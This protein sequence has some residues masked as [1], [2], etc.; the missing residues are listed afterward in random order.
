F[1]DQRDLDERQIKVVIMF[2]I[3]ALPEALVPVTELIEDTGPTVE[4]IRDGISRWGSKCSVTWDIEP[5]DLVGYSLFQIQ[6]ALVHAM[7]TCRVKVDL[8]SEPVPRAAVI[9]ALDRLVK[10]YPIQSYH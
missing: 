9:M 4:E 5:E 2:G 8:S 3:A 10:P 1:A 7:V 6:T